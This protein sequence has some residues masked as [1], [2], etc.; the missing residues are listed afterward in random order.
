MM[1]FGQLAAL[2]TSLCFTATSTFFTL[3]GRLVSALV[4]N[5]TRLLLATLFLTV[6]HLMFGI[7]LPTS[8]EPF[9]YFWLVLSGVIGLALGD[10]FL[11]QAFVWIGPRLSMLMM[12]LAPV[13]AVL[14]SWA[15]LG[16]FLSTSQLLGILLTVSGVGWVVMDRRGRQGVTPISNRNYA[17][18][19]LFGL[20]AAFGQAAGLVTAKFGLVGDFP[21]LSGTLIRMVAAAL[22]LWAITL[23]QGQARSTFARVR[24]HPRAM[25]YITAGAFFGPTLGVTLSLI[26]I[27]RIPVG[28]ASTL[29][30]LPPVLL[31]PVG[32]LVFGERFGWQAILG[33]LV[34]IT[35]VAVLFLV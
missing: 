33:T 35:G 28:I 23:L 18:G 25:A 5:R 21:A 14:M 9:R 34:A 8:A 27:Q 29:T 1:L 30:S 32:R 2:G 31:I 6:A 26:A 19:I 17:L 24:S 15:F 12:S 3:G 13:M 16:E 10:A 22:V 11:F 20:G 7:P 4:V